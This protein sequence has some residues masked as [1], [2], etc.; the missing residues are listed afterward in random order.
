MKNLWIVLIFMGSL[1]SYEATAQQR[2]R[3]ERIEQHRGDRNQ[4]RTDVRQGRCKKAKF[5]HHRKMRRLA[6]IDGRITPR[7]RRVLRNNIRRVF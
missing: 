3:G 2:F 6:A 7:E 4:Y 5:R 1:I